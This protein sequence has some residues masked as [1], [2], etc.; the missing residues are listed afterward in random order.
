MSSGIVYHIQCDHDHEEGKNV[1]RGRTMKN[2]YSRGQEH[3]DSY[4]K[5]RKDS[6][7]WRDCVEKHN[8]QKQTFSMSV[9]DNHK[10]DATMVQI[11]EALRIRE[12]DKELRM[13]MRNEWNIIR[14]PQVK[15]ENAQ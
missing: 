12:I 5:K 7:M 11:K 10:D 1:Y 3:M 2:G 13:N 14:L 6:V 9:I 8:G 15:V 4:V